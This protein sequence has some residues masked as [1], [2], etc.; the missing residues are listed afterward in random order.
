MEKSGF[1]ERVTL[2]EGD[3]AG[4]PFDDGQFDWV[5]SADCV[6]YPGG[7]AAPALRELARVVR[8]GGRIALLGWSAQQVLP[9]HT[10]LEARL[11][12]TCSAYQPFLGGQAPARHFARAASAVLGPCPWP[13]GRSC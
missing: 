6:A 5:W 9:G 3:V 11:K 8:P 7:D 12:A 10:L 4:L 13:P 2:V 1:A